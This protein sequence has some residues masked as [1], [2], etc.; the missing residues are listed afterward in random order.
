MITEV[1]FIKEQLGMKQMM[2]KKVETG[3]V[4]HTETEKKQ[5]D[6]QRGR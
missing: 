4:F 6:C 5:H 3:K 1:G 2:R